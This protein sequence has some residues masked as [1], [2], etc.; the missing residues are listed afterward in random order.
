[1]P[2]GM[3]EYLAAP[4]SQ[5]AVLAQ[6][7]PNRGKDKDLLSDRQAMQGVCYALSARWIRRHKDFKSEG[8]GKRMQYLSGEQVVVEAMQMQMFAF[9]V[10]TALTM[11]Q[12]ETQGYLTSGAVPQG[13]LAE[14]RQIMN[15]AKGFQPGE[16]QQ[17]A[18]QLCDLAGTSVNMDDVAIGAVNLEQRIA[19]TVAATSGVHNYHMIGITGEDG[20]HA[21]ACYKS[22]GGIFSSAH[23]Y[24]FD[25][26]RGEYK[27]PSSK[28]SAFISAYLAHSERATVGQLKSIDVKRITG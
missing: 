23:L 22:G 21:V 13:K 10:R 9:S 27:I 20:G 1:M 6:H 8:P 18:L 11:V 19:Q 24:F 28:V 2:A 5:N 4:F 15:A 14:I 25:S 16:R 3:D 26:N 17:K 12:D 7:Y